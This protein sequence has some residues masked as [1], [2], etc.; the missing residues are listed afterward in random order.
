MRKSIVALTLQTSKLD[1]K[2][3]TINKKK[4]LYV[5]NIARNVEWLYNKA[6]G[7]SMVAS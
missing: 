4:A 5:C 6:K 3:E 1:R 2:L 7:I